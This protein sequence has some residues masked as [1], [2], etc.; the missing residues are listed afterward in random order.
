MAA[1]RALA[2]ALAKV[3][4]MLLSERIANR[5]VKHL[6]QGG[7]APQSRAERGREREREKRYDPECAK[8][9]KQSRAKANKQDNSKRRRSLERA[10]SHQQRTGE[11]EGEES[12]VDQDTR[13]RRNEKGV[14]GRE[15]EMEGERAAAEQADRQA[16][17]CCLPARL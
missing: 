8:R 12:G 11:R 9:A 17:K 2:V 3:R 14:R 15:S 7:G 13:A 5:V 4:A 1:G 6:E 10:A 16:G